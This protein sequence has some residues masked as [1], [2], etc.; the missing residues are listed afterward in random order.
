MK[1]WAAEMAP[2]T[3]VDVRYHEATEKNFIRDFG[4]FD[5][6]DLKVSDF[7]DSA[8]LTASLLASATTETLE[9]RIAW[10][11][12][13]YCRL[14]LRWRLTEREFAATSASLDEEFPTSALK[15]SGRRR[16][17]TLCALQQSLRLRKLDLK[18]SSLTL[19]ATIVLLLR[20]QSLRLCPK[21]NTVAATAAPSN[22]VPAPLIAEA[23]RRLPSFD[24]E[25]ELLS[26]E[27]EV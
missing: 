4:N 19:H 20:L 17:D 26:K 14:S 24:L 13:D 22:A 18:N 25:I 11:Y 27:M 15:H 23:K 5:L 12:R 1:R 9:S 6:L 3:D 16:Y 7:P 2:I 10:L 8:Q 21:I